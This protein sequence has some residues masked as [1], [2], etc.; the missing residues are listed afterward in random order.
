MNKLFTTKKLVL[1]AVF[2]ALA[3]V[4]MLFEFPLPFIAPSFYEIDLSEVPV[5]L[6]SFIMGPVAGVIIEAIK[7]ILKVLIK[8]TTTGYVGDVANF[9][10]GCCLVVPAG[11]AYKIKKSKKAALIGLAIGTLIMILG[12]V[13]ANYYFLI[14]IYSKF[15]PLDAI[16][17]AG[18]AINPAVSSTLSLVFICV[19]PFNLLKGIIVSLITVLLYKRTSNFIKNIGH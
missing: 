16:I 5:L 12:G 19:A 11:V 7:I 18:K 17:Q 6:G 10:I 2:S 13:I 9:I 15:M 14:P 8:G 4:L 1:I 3:F